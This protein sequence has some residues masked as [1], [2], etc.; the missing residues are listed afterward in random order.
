MLPILTI[1]L[2]PAL[3]VTTTVDR[4][5]PLQKLR[6]TEPRL[7]PGGGGVNVSRAIKELGG[8]SRA[9]LA[10]GGAIGEELKTLLDRTGIACDYWPLIEQTRFSF[11]VM[12]EATAEHY[13]FV[14]PGPHVSPAESDFIL[15][16]LEGLIRNNP[17]YVIASGSLP[18]GVPLDFCARLA[19]LTRERGA[20][21]I[22]DTHGEPLRLAAA[23]R[24]HIIR[25]NHLEAQELVG[26]D[27]DTAAHLLAR[28]LIER[29]L[30][31]AAIITLGD[32]GAIVATPGHEIEIRPP[33]VEVR[34]S[35]GAGDSFVAALTFGLASGWAIEEAARYGVAAAA[36]A[37]TTEATELCKR[38]TV[39]AFFA[40]IGGELR[41]A[42]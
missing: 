21:L 14:L 41:P 42:A 17:G 5:K 25:L 3:D 6:C 13:R 40:Q 16:H 39:N 37:V 32:R 27:S 22:I 30:A 29:Q 7:D 19:R 26:G 34:S 38:D 2:N 35:V 18:L 15:A 9:F 31:D 24:P 12:E 36:A 1:T 8:E 10:I 4:L 11:T 20:K 23:E 33:H 28:Q